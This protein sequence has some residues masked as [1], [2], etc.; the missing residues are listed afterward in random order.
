[1]RCRLQNEAA[2]TAQK[3]LRCTLL[4][5]GSYTL[6]SRA[7]CCTA[8]V[9]YSSFCTLAAALQLLCSTVQHS[10]VQYSCRTAAA[11]RFCTL[12]AAQQLLCS[13]VQYCCCCTA[14][15]I[16]FCTAAAAQQLLC[17]TAAAAQ[18]L[19]YSCFYKHC[20]LRSTYGALH[21]GC[22]TAA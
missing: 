3:A 12:A 10:T 14:A 17:S 13:T 20:M 8:A 1:M 6:H 2:H 16:R 21:D 22:M 4:Y 19:L 5:T 9:P 11:V 7:S 15:A 18:Q